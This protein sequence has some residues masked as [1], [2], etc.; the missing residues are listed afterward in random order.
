MR[1]GPLLWTLTVTAPLISSAWLLPARSLV[2]PT[3]PLRP[4]RVAMCSGNRQHS[5][6]QQREQKNLRRKK[7]AKVPARRAGGER[8]PKQRRGASTRRNLLRSVCAAVRSGDWTFV[9]DTLDAEQT[10]SIGEW[11]AM[12]QAT[13]QVNDWEGALQLL[14]RLG[15]PDADAF[16]YAISACAR[17]N[18]P[19]QAHELLDQLAKA[20]VE[21]PA[22]A[23]NIVISSYARRKEWHAALQMLE[24]TP[25]RVRNVVSYNAALSACKAAARWE[26]ALELLARMERDGPPP[27]IVSYS[28]AA[29]ACQKAKRWEPALELLERLNASSTGAGGR[30]VIRP[31]APNAFTYT[32]AVVAL[33]EAGKWEEALR[34][35]DSMPRTLERNEAV[36]NAAVGAAAT[37]KDWRSAVRVLDGAVAGGVRPRASSYTMAINSLADD[38]RPAAALALLRRMREAGVRP[39]IL[40]YNAVLRA[41]ERSGRWRQAARLLRE[42]HRSRLRPSLISYNLALGACAKGSKRRGKAG[43]KRENETR[44]VDGGAEV[45][46]MAQPAAGED[47]KESDDADGASPLAA[48][49]AWAS[50]GSA[51]S[52]RREQKKEITE[53]TDPMILRLT[54]GASST[55]TDTGEDP[56]APPA[57]GTAG[58]E[59]PDGASAA[60]GVEPERA[61]GAGTYD[62]KS[63]AANEQATSAG[64]MAMRLLTELQR[65]GHTPDVVSYSSAI[66]ALSHSGELERVIGLL[67]VMEERRLEPNAFSWSAAINACERAGEWEKAL[68]LF[69][70]LRDAGGAADHA[71]YH[72]AISAAASSGDSSLARTLMAQMLAE[73][74]PPTLRAYNSVLKA[75]ERTAD[76]TV[77]FDVLGEMKAAGFAPDRIS[78][79]CAVGAAGRA[80]EWE[81]ALALWTTMVTEGVDIDAMALHTLLKALTSAGQ[82]A[83]CLHV[84]GHVL[85]MEDHEV[86]TSTVFAAALEACAA[87]A[88]RERALSLLAKMKEL[89]ILASPV[90]YHFVAASCAAAGDWRGACSAL[91]DVLRQE[92]RPDSRTWR[93][94]YDT[95]RAAGRDEEANSVCGLAVREGVP[96]LTLQEGTDDGASD[97]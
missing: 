33:S 71:V 5:D 24:A 76:Y 2:V 54:E 55:S 40:T 89:R 80:G 46:D 77:A 13:S 73:G 66:A 48:A 63:D 22:R 81:K 50:V 31:P 52:S 1:P 57:A 51:G 49:M 32:S 35:Y 85:E 75:C 10:W 64:E 87:G 45:V 70:G 21:A 78:Y 25:A 43:L 16:G 42:M 91:Q 29:A 11:R 96:L 61:T 37:G 60:G 59:R 84:F 23:Y 86:R 38:M 68:A 9:N 67:G 79:T 62:A 39:N 93:L 41:L 15:R 4:L 53:L 88:Q 56:T 72:A 27:D 94:V 20:G 3:Q 82:W 12:L 69:A 97:A 6:L 74:L 95:C 47:D 28:T 8:P 90:C 18:Q 17:A 30:N 83:V 92:M 58:R 34:T 44:A 26:E 14:G 65:T 19:E 36:V 7:T